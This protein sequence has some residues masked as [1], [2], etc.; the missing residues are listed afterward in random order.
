MCSLRLQIIAELNM[1]GHVGRDRT[2]QL[3]VS[4]YFWPS[5]WRDVELTRYVVCQ[6]SKGNATNAGL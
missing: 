6:H 1:E 3:L 4:S 2:L 5:L